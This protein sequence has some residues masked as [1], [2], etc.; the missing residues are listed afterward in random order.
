M[1]YART[2]ASA[3]IVTVTGSLVNCGA[4]IGAS[5][6]LTSYEGIAA[7]LRAAMADPK[8]SSILLDLNTPGGEATGA[9]ELAALVRQ[10]NAAKPVNAFINGIAAS[11][12]YLMASGAGRIASV[13]T[14]I[15]GSIGV[16]MMQADYSRALEKA[17]ITPTLIYAGKRKVDGNPYRPLDADTKARLQAE[18]D[19]MREDFVQLVAK[20]HGR[21][22][23]AKAVRGTEAAVFTGKDALAAG[24]V[25]ELMSFDALYD[26]MNRSAGIT[27][28]AG[29][30][31]GRRLTMEEAA[32]I[33]AEATVAERAR[34]KVILTAGSQ[35]TRRTRIP[36]GLRDAGWARRGTRPRLPHDQRTACLDLR[37]DLPRQGQGGRLGPAPLQHGSDECA[38]PGHQPH[39][40]PP[41]PRRADA[42]GRRLAR[43]RRPRRPQH[44]HAAA[45]AAPGPGT[46][47]S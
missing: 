20:G 8:V 11:A 38:S 21:R 27:R 33:R 35:G 43:R 39:R 18:V 45:T 25:D 41:R 17:G 24:L 3:A 28:P 36:P 46:Q 2:D 37:G 16:V 30:P 15:T 14:G 10:A 4:W 32:Q 1:P 9:F 31:Q 22:T 13:P 12:G 44:H 42:G 40:R 26:T 5:S 23:S 34:I 47:P 6:G 29:K 19:A 7:Q